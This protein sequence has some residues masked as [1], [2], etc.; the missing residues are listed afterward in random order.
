MSRIVLGLSYS[1]AQFHGW[2][3]QREGNTVQ[4][5]LEAALSKIADHEVRVICAGRTD[6]GVHATRQIVHFD[7]SVIRPEKAWVLGTNAHLADSVAVSW[8]RIVDETFSARFSATARRYL[9][10]IHNTAVRSAIGAGLFTREHRPLDTAKMHQAAQALLGEHDF[11]AYR[12]SKCQSK[13]PLRN[14]HEITVSRRGE[15][16][17]V[18]INAKAFLHHMVRTSAG[19]LMNIGAGERAVDW[20]AELLEGRD[21]TVGAMTAPP[22]G[23]YLVDVVYPDTFELPQGPKIPH[24]FADQ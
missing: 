21:R 16:V 22:H 9:Y 15:M 2:Q 17:L 1:G 13:T 10:C 6:T 18:N 4:Q 12:A 14:I 20:S 3:A 7:T 23:L 19:V 11:S 8:S 24:F 5:T